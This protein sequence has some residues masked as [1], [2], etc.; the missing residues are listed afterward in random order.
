MFINK[1]EK[2]IVLLCADDCLCFAYDEK[3]LDNLV[4]GLKRT[5]DLD[6]QE[7]SRDV[8]AYLGI[9]LNMQGDEVECCKQD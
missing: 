3:S 4:K 7:M 5:H 6:E 8:C 1:K 2:V 9:E